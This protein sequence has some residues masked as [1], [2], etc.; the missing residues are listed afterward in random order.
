MTH[1]EH[2]NQAVT[3]VDASDIR[4]PELESENEPSEFPKRL[5]GL[6][7]QYR[8][9][10]LRQYEIP[11]SKATLL[12]ILKSATWVEVLL[13]IFATILSIG[14]GIRPLVDKILSRRR[15]AANGGRVW[16]F[17]EYIWRSSAGYAGCNN[18]PQC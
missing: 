9:E 18:S 1:K 14:A 8:E 17:D 5:E 4:A 12:T 6:P 16:E 7:K 11:T 2:S 13:M 10:I 15:N 3:V